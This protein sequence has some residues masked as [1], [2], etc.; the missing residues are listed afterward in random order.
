M[1]VFRGRIMIDYLSLLFLLPSFY[2]GSVHSGI[3]QGR[4]GGG[5]DS[6]FLPLRLIPLPST[7]E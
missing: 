6:G 2:L 4:W 3:G 7:I 5:V 1:K